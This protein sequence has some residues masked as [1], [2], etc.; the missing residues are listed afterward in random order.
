MTDTINPHPGS[1]KKIG[2]TFNMPVDWHTRFKMRSIQDGMNMTEMLYQCF[3]AYELLEEYQA[4]K[5]TLHANARRS[6]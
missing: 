3:L 2:M 4:R 1:N 5:R 6:T